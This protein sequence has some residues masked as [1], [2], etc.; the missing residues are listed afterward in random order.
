MFFVYNRFF[1]IYI[2]FMLI[3]THCHLNS[4]QFDCGLR[5]VVDRAIGA[6]VE[7]IVI[8]G[9]NYESCLEAI[10]I[11]NSF[12]NCYAVIGIHPD[13]GVEWND[14][15]AAELRAFLGGNNKIV[16]LGEVGLDY[17]WD[18]LP[19]SRQKEIF[20]EQIAIAREL[21]LPLVIHSREAVSDCLELLL[22]NDVRKA[23]FHCFSGTLEIARSIW[24]AGFHTSFTGIVT[25]PGASSIR[26]VVFECPKD[27]IM[28]E[29]DAPYL[30]PQSVRGVRCEP[31]HLREIFL[32]ICEIRSE[33]E[34]KMEK[35]LQD[36]SMRFFGI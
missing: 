26:D 7:A 6:G 29:T 24:R 21:D 23:V 28:I 31:A 19:R 18:T 8:P 33:D 11:V 34:E 13:D 35:I 15:L 12:A 1:Y 4:S 16:G 5:E 25:Y 3:D 9:Y 32:K 10:R 17:H 30:A 36:N 14:A 22:E 20:V 2:L 27:R